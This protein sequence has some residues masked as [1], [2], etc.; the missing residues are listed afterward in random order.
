MFRRNR[1]LA[2]LVTSLADKPLLYEP[3]EGW[4]WCYVEQIVF[5]LVGAPPAAVHT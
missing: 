4:C 1:T 2:D 5:E 3:G